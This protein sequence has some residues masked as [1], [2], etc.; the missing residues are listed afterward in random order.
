[1]L[2]NESLLI[3]NVYLRIVHFNKCDK[4]IKI[5]KRFKLYLSIFII[6]F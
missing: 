6:N 4:K 3:N 2:V 5:F 1:M